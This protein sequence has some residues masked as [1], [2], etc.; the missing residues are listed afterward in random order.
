MDNS[1]VL[2]SHSQITHVYMEEVIWQERVPICESLLR[3]PAFL[4]FK[5]LQKMLHA[6]HNLDF[7]LDHP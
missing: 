1:L 3:L 2:K 4:E 5:D 6:P 7:T